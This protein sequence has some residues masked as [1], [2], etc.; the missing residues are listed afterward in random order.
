[1]YECIH[2]YMYVCILIAT[3][4]K[5]NFTFSSLI[6]II[7]YCKR[8][9]V[10]KAVLA[11]VLIAQD[12]VTET[13]LELRPVVW[14]LNRRFISVRCVRQIYSSWFLYFQIIQQFEERKEEKHASILWSG[15]KTTGE[16]FCIYVVRPNNLIPFITTSWGPRASSQGI[17]GFRGILWWSLI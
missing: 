15:S 12:S 16:C 2:A 9:K 5:N 4:G 17:K 13:Y 10:L 11:F 6:T 8:W 1:M 3:W 7:T 14:I